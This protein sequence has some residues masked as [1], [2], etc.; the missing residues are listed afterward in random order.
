MGERGPTGHTAEDGGESI[1]PL[2]RH[3]PL[4]HISGQ[5]LASSDQPPSHAAVIREERFVRSDAMA[6]EL[7]IADINHAELSCGYG[8][9]MGT[10]K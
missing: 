7:E 9:N 3:H 2:D 6:G 8:V 1:R 5:P 10:G 4:K